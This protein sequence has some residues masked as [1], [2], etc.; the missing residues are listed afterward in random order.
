ME[1]R[2]N[3][4]YEMI[5]RALILKQSLNC[6]TQKEGFEGKNIDSNLWGKYEELK[7]FLQPFYESTVLISR[8][9]Y[10][11]LIIV[12]P[13]FDKLL[14][15]LKEYESKEI[16][17]KCALNIEEKLLKYKKELNNDIVIFA[18]ILDPRLKLEFFEK[19]DNFQEIKEKFECNFNTNYKSYAISC[20]V[21][22]TQESN[23]F[24]QSLYKK[25]KVNENDELKTYF[26]K[27]LEDY[28][29][30]PI[31]W[32]NKNKDCFPNISKMAFD[33]ITIPATSVPSEQV[34]SRAGDLI[35]KK[36]NRL[37]KKQLRH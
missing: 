16:I 2:W 31:V 7:R 20:D 15:H 13:I 4:A 1:T 18:S 21:S 19:W 10:P 22:K 3:S 12:L 33:Y 36:R 28:S 25:Q 34:F 8:S 30:D 26:E 29:T 35:T 24:T 5:E 32:W 11:T 6:L 17:K 14:S 37:E 27:S 23:S 9:S